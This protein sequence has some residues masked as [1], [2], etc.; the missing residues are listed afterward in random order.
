MKKIIITEHES[1]NYYQ[2]LEMSTFPSAGI[3]LTEVRTDPENKD[4]RVDIIS[5]SKREL[6]AI[7]KEFC[8]TYELKEE[9]QYDHSF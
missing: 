4:T 1:M 9:Y 6:T 2:R 3:I 8:R 7:L 5:M